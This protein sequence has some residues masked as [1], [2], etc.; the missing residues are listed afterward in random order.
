MELMHNCAFMVLSGDLA[1]VYRIVVDAPELGKTI[2][3]RLGDRKEPADVDKLAD[4]SPR[5]ARKCST[6]KEGNPR[7]K[8][9]H[10]LVGAPLWLDRDKLLVLRDQE[11]LQEVEIVLDGICYQTPD[12]ELDPHSSDATKKR[13]ERKQI[14]LRK[15]IEAMAPFLSVDSMRKSLLE[16]R[17][18]SQLV[19]EVTQRSPKKEKGQTSTGRNKKAHQDGPTISRGLVYKCL[20]LLARYGFHE[21]SL[22]LRFDRSGAK[23]VPR[24]CAPG[25]RKKPGARTEIQRQAKLAGIEIPPPEQPGMS[26]AWRDLVL[27]A[28]SKIPSPK[29]KW[30]RRCTLI[31]NAAFV[32]KMKEENGAMVAIKP[33]RG[34]YP[35]DEQIQ[36][37]IEFETPRLIR[38]RQGTTTGHFNRSLRGLNGKSWQGVSGPGH[39]WAID[40]T[41]GDIYLRSSIKRAWVIGRPIVYILVDVW[42][43]AVTGFYVCLR[44][45]SWDMA[46]ISLFCAGASPE[47][48]ADLWGYEFFPTLVP[49][50][51]LPA[52]LMCDRGEYLS[53]AAKQTGTLL[54][55][56]ESFAPPYRPD[57][58][59]LV[60]VLHRIAKD[61]QF[62]FVPGSIDARIREMERRR[63]DPQ[64]AIFTVREYV[65]HLYLHFNHYN[66][67]ADRSHRL[68]VH[69]IADGAVPSPAGLW[70][71]GHGV[72]LGHSRKVDNHQ[73]VTDLLP[74]AAISVTRRG[75]SFAR[76]VYAS[77]ETERD[78]WTESARNF[79]AD[80]QRKC[81]YFPGSTDRIWTPNLAGKGLLNLHLDDHALISGDAT[82]DEVADV[83]KYS[84][85]SNGAR[86][87]EKRMMA[88]DTLAMQKANI[89]V[90]TQRTSEALAAEADPPPSLTDARNL[91]A[92]PTSIT[93]SAASQAH[94]PRVTA[95]D[96]LFLEMMDSILNSP[97]DG[98]KASD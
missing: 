22:T 40:S 87:H 37:V 30:P 75:V 18:F 91:E 52:M 74:S 64:T 16:N 44:G 66:L 70:R 31:V 68:D 13:H 43:T 42:S 6:R 2:V 46:K 90:A 11:M 38:L 62:E 88:L 17:N 55:L 28:D 61:E 33:E 54:R 48:V 39:T 10:R 26:A 51:T 35:N 72:G 84:L 59:G 95:Q 4:E 34:T 78:K 32:R 82:F 92:L 47:L 41:V 1:G 63:F 25:G 5:G 7:E 27:W 86:T 19:R 15:R 73:L 94:I 23:G 77:S 83:L 81:H 71:W 3:M 79:G 96:P 45:P 9:C 53:R 50:P 80:H 58:K 14:L 97:A 65:Q 29:P 93:A 98:E 57:L 67:T 12:A 36:H 24:P 69:M 60:E 8:E 21:S 89:D 56:N 76:G 20:T 49:Y 85:R